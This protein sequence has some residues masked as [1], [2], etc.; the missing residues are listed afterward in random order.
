MGCCVSTWSK[1]PKTCAKIHLSK[2]KRNRGKSVT[3]VSGGKSCG[4]SVTPISVEIKEETWFDPATHLE[5]DCDEDFLSCHGDFLSST[6]NNL[7]HPNSANVTPR[8]SLCD[9][10]II[11]TSGEKGLKLGELLSENLPCQEVNAVDEA[12]DFHGQ[13]DVDERQNTNSDLTIPKEIKNGKNKVL[14]FSEGNS[15]V[16]TEFTVGSECEE[17]KV[18][19]YCGVQL[20]ASCLPCLIPN[21]GLI[22]KK[23]SLSP[24]P[25][26]SKKKASLLKLSFKR[27]SADGHENNNVFSSIKFLE[28]PKAGSQ[29]PFCSAEKAMPGSWSQIEPS[30]FKLRGENYLKDKKK[31]IAPNYA[32]YYPFGVDVFQCHRKIDHIARHVELPDFDSSGKMP[33]ILIV[34]IQIPSYPA[35]IFLGESD[36]E[37]ISIV[38]YFKLSDSYAKETTAHFQESIQKLMDDEIEKVKGFALDSFVPFRERLKILGRVANLDDL[39]VSAAE[40]KLIHAYNEKPVLSR[41]QHSFYKGPNYFEIDL[42][43]HRFS[44]I[45][46]KGIEAFQNQMKFGILDIGLTIQG[47]KPEELPEQVLCCLRLNMIDPLNYKQLLTTLHPGNSEGRIDDYRD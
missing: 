24:G 33:P 43:V 32:A 41:P 40:K 30:S 19:D 34:N 35:A 31:E 45:A 46:R 9:N 11:L 42:D 8:H 18:V 26:S 37:G 2:R 14:G 20:N 44:Y 12:S 36:G 47:N 28:R 29:V 27:R 15:H 4:T 39:H 25:P 6:C 21:V 13:N 16:L 10:H 17:E 7:S 1:K 38:F 23:R 3:P 5:S 22:E